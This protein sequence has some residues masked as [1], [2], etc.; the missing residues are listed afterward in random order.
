MSRD[1]ICDFSV[2]LNG[3][4]FYLVASYSGTELYVERDRVEPEIE[5]E[6]QAASVVETKE[7]AEESF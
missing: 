3:D 1:R 2:L 6:V 7:V 4:V 5:P